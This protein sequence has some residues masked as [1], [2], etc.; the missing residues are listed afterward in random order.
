MSGP[1][2]T[3]VQPQDFGP[4]SSARRS[5]RRQQGIAALLRISTLRPV[6]VG[7]RRNP[8]EKA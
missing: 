1:V 2:Q 3:L 6:P 5:A 7:V 4:R 8:A